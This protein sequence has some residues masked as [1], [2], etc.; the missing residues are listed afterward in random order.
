MNWWHR[1]LVALEGVY[2]D[3]L[4]ESAY[5]VIG[6]TKYSGAV[7]QNILRNTW[8]RCSPYRKVGPALMLRATE[9]FSDGYCYETIPDKV[10]LD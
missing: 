2:N 1:D 10:Y 8:T 9:A 5:Q 3:L 6:T 4:P 7:L